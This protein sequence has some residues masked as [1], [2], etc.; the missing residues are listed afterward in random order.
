MQ[1]QDRPIPVTSPN[2][3]PLIGG[4]RPFGSIKKLLDTVINRSA[5]DWSLESSLDDLG[6]YFKLPANWWKDREGMGALILNAV[7][8]A[9][10]DAW[11]YYQWLRE[12]RPELGDT[13]MEFFACSVMHPE[14]IKA[15]DQQWRH[16]PATGGNLYDVLP[17]IGDFMHPD[18]PHNIAWYPSYKQKIGEELNLR[19]CESYKWLVNLF[20][21]RNEDKAKKL[22]EGLNHISLA[23]IKGD[24]D[25][26]I[27]LGKALS[28]TFE[29]C[30]T[31]TLEQIQKQPISRSRK[32]VTQRQ[33]CRRLWISR[34]LWLLPPHLLQQEPFSLSYATVGEL[35]G[36]R[37]SG[38]KE[39]LQNDGLYLTESLWCNE[40]Q[41]DT[42]SVSLTAE[43]RK[44]LPNHREIGLPWGIVSADMI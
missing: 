5:W 23:A 38:N 29:P 16:Y 25:F 10:A 37:Y 11:I 35:T 31:L 9:F 40:W 8:A 12:N 3:P 27:T 21:S 42:K 41:D 24:K 28:E 19:A 39:L 6:C 13:Y 4:N 36:K 2:Y 43:G 26:F 30:Q 33:W 14:W 32:G 15:L 34:G 44:M 1:L 7:A 20:T 18:N 17:S 22:E